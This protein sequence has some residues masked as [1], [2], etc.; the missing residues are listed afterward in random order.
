MAVPNPIKVLLVDDHPLVRESLTS[1]ID[2]Q[3]DMS[4][5]GDA[6]DIADAVRQ[7]KACQPDIAIVDLSLK[8]S[9]GLELV[10]SIKLRWPDIGVIVLSMHDEGQ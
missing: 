6:E 2:Q 3:E 9:S 7:I 4:V 8:A 5:C 1:L 10:K